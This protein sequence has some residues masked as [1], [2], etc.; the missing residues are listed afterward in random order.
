MSY[1]NYFYVY[2]KSTRYPL[3]KTLVDPSQKYKV[4]AQTASW[5]YARTTRYTSRSAEMDNI[6][7]D[8]DLFITQSQSNAGA[9]SNPRMSRPQAWAKNIVGVG[10]FRHYNNTNPADDCW[11][12][13]GS[14]GP[15]QDGGVGV[16][17]AAYYDSIRTTGYSSSSYTTG[18]GGTSGA[19]PII[20]G[21]GQIAIQMFTEGMFGHPKAPDWRQRFAYKPHF[22]TTKCLL[23]ATSRQLPLNRA[24]RV[25][26]GYGFPSMQDLYD[27]RN[28]MLVLDELDV[29]RQGQSRTYYV[30]VKPGTKEFRSVMHHADPPGNPAVTRR[31]INSLNMKV[32]DPNGVSY[33]GQHGLMN[34]LT[35]TPGGVR[36]DVEVHE[37]VILTNPPAGVWSVEVQAEAIRQD[38]HKET[39]QVDADFALVVRGIGGGRDKTGAK[40]DL[41]SS[42]PGDFRVSLT[43]LPA[44]WT[45]GYTLFSLSTKRPVAM[46]NVF[47]LEADDLTLAILSTP[48]SRGNVFAFTNGGGSVYPGAPY[49]FPAEIALLLRGRTIDGVAFVVDGRG[50]IVAAS[51]VDRVTIR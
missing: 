20:N 46:G 12:R 14:T 47:G 38:S 39:P 27:L 3:T 5:G 10:G 22:T 8:L 25:Q 7:F 36:D 1:T 45:S 24:T 42:A 51:S 35:S 34:S 11:C 30:W 43:G 26:Q 50:R 13:S 19:T 17:L 41:I 2:N 37:H 16:T 49:R 32:T 6:I 31:R 15:A 28:N 9:T 4:M 21:Y 44:G 18:F 40:L 29:L 23:T 48:P 33:W